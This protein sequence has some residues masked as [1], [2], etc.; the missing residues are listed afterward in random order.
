MAKPGRP[1]AVDDGAEM[2]MTSQETKADPYAAQRARYEELYKR[3]KAARRDFGEAKGNPKELPNELLLWRESLPGGWGT[4]VA[5]PRG[6]TLRIVA[7]AATQGVS[8]LLFRQAEPT[9]R[10]NVGDTVKVQWSAKLHKGKLLYSDMGRVLA[11]IA[12]DSYGRH[13]ALAG[14]S[15][16]FTNAAKYGDASLRSTRGNFILL[17]AKHGL[18]KADIPPCVTL[19]APVTVDASGRFE[20]TGPE[21]QPG[22]YVD[23]RAEMDVLVFLSNCSHPLAPGDYAPQPVDL[24][25]WNSPEAR[26][27]DFCRTSCE[28]ARRGFDN[29]DALTGFKVEA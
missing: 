8:I 12:D 19:F 3:G 10:L 22:D 25:L 27:D 9:E 6:R 13:D 4:S 15:T 1:G 24:L 11:S 7:G 14:G 29:T 20:W 21:A 2:N 16:A 17:S 23:L 5:V 18:S 26:A 28:E